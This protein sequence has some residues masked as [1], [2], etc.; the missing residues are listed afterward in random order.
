MTAIPTLDD[1]EVITAG[2]PYELIVII[3]EGDPAAPVDVSARTYA[4]QV[5]AH[6]NLTAPVLAS[7][8]PHMDDADTGTVRFTLTSAQTRALYGQI[9]EGGLDVQETIGS[10]D[11]ETLFAAEVTVAGDYTR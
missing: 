8:T 3:E 7:L 5:R 9:T 6:T 10:A 4:C 11:P 2:D 1:P